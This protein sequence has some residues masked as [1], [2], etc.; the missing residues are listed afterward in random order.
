MKWI[1]GAED[2]GGGVQAHFLEP[3]LHRPLQQSA[4]RV[5]EALE[6]LQAVLHV[7]PLKP[8]TQ[9]E[10]AV[11][12]EQTRQFAGHAEHEALVLVRL[13]NCRER[14]LREHV[15]AATVPQLK[16]V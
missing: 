5:T 1:G 4:Q 16:P 3:P 11:R 15:G 12:E 9:R 10:Q 14:H 8:A 2:N 6:A 7:A 13:Q